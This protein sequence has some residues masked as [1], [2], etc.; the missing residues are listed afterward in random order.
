[1]G[2]SVFS[3]MQTFRKSGS[4]FV[5]HVEPGR[6]FKIVFIGAFA[7]REIHLWFSLVEYSPTHWKNPVPEHICSSLPC[8][9]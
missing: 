8:S 5:S 2:L 3:H 9:L 7:G 4:Q 6:L 1:M